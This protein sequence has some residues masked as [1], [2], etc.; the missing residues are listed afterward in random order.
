MARP[1]RIELIRRIEA[2]RKSRIICCLTSDRQIANGIIA[3][4]FIPIFSEHLRGF[5]NTTN[6]DDV[7]VYDGRR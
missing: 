4:D 5:D 7:F 2:H 6:V 1:E 3:E